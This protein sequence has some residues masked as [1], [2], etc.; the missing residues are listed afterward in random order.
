MID[1]LNSDKAPSEEPKTDE[2]TPVQ[3]TELDNA[4]AVEST[5]EGLPQFESFN[6]VNVVNEGSRY[7]KD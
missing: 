1:A 4:L 7:A 3:P 6:A 5:P 2:E